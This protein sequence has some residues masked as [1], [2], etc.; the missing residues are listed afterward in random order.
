MTQE[1]LPVVQPFVG[2]AAPAIVQKI[3]DRL[4]RTVDQLTAELTSIFGSHLAL[5]LRRCS[6]VKTIASSEAPVPL[7]EIYVN[8]SLSNSQTSISDGDL[9]SRVSK[10]RNAII[11]GTA[12]AGKTM[13]M[14]YLAL[15]LHNQTGGK[16]PCSYS[17]AN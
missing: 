12:G 6:Y 3:A 13:M 4:K 17:F 5:T 16:I 14:R 15:S 1:W 8:L 11:V 2:A 7:N 9:I 10:G